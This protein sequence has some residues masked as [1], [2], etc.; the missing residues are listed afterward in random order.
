MLISWVKG[1][2]ERFNLAKSEWAATEMQPILLTSTNPYIKE[3]LA[4]RWLKGCDTVANCISGFMV[5][6]KTKIFCPLQDLVVR[7][8]QKSCR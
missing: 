7:D 6:K 1:S 5:G 4:F 2:I 8:H 3:Q